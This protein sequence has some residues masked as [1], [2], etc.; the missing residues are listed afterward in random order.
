MFLCGLLQTVCVRW[1]WTRHWSVLTRSWWILLGYGKFI[2]AHTHSRTHFTAPF[3]GLPGWAG[4]RRNLLGF[5]VQGK[6]TEAD[7]QYNP[8]GHYSVRTN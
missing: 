5:M 4:A 6:I 7:T 1:L 8:V 2:S 3:L